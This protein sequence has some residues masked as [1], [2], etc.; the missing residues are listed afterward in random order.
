MAKDRLTPC[1][2]YI[3][4]G[5]CK[6]GRD[7]CHRGYCQHCEKYKPRA[8]ERHLNKKKQKIEKLRKEGV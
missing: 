6:K 8:K 7:A 1:L 3:A 2:F 4:K 5:S